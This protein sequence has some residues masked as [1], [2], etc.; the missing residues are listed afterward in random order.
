M[1][2]VLCHLAEDIWQF[3]PG[4][5]EAS[6]FLT[7]W[8]KKF[9]DQPDEA[10]ASIADL[11]RVLDARDPLNLALEKARAQKLLG[12]GLEARAVLTVVQGSEMHSALSAI[13][14][15]PHQV[16]DGLRY[17]MGVSELE[18][19]ATETL[20]DVEDSDE[21][22][23]QKSEELV[24]TL[25]RATGRKCERCWVRCE[26]V[27]SSAAH[28]DLC[29]RCESVVLELGMKTAPEAATA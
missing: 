18:L 14:S 1:G 22:V 25:M 13:A 16:A 6:V 29:S 8:W 2:P 27:G 3:L 23:H 24:A 28:P 10:E 4:E 5:K 17:L 26:T 9:P 20:P 11:A 12:G 21:A 19:V 7:G 15:S